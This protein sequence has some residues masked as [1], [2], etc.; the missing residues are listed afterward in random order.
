MQLRLSIAAATLLISSASMAEDY[1]TFQYLQYD[2]NNNRTSVSAPSVSINKDFGTDYTLNLSL[3]IDA[4][5]GATPT[6][7]IFDTTSGASAYSRGKGI[8]A[9]D[10]RY[11]NVQYSDT[12]KAP[13]LL[14]TTRFD[15]RDELKVGANYSSEN[16]FYSTE[17]SLEY[18]HWLD[19]SKNSSISFGAS[20]QANEI[21]VGCKYNEE[22]D[23][24]SGASQKMD[25]QVINAQVSF[26]Q[27]INASSYFKAS[28]YSITEGGYLSNP[29]YNIVRNNNGITADVVAERRPDSRQAYGAMLKYA[30]ALTSDTTI[31]LSY[32]FYDD[33]WDITSNTLDSDL[34]YELAQDWIFNLGLRVYSQSAASFYN[35]SSRYF[36]DET[37]ASSDKRLSEFISYTYK[38]NVDYSISEEWSVNF[39]ANYYEQTTG[40]SATYFM[41]G[42]RYNF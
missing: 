29:Y 26:F 20:Y 42:F 15:N 4:V 24:S 38:V 17:G 16:D 40:L 28:F 39:S 32:R 7:Y 33:N 34:Y 31:H 1:V 35:G 27:N 37:Y 8:D 30:N 12:R 18:M 19:S 13:S 3:T 11:G 9:D 10:V 23:A 14:F 5:S 25:A 22:C 2:E 21:L 6:Y 41:S 36:S